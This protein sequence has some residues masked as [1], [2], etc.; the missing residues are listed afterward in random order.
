MNAVDQRRQWA[1]WL[2]GHVAEI[3]FIQDAPCRGQVDVYFE[4]VQ[5]LPSGLSI[6]L[7][8]NVANPEVLAEEGFLA[9]VL[10]RAADRAADLLW[11]CSNYVEAIQETA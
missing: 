6:S 3:K 9:G 10:L 4:K 11:T 1:E 2:Q 5:E 7:N 8:Y